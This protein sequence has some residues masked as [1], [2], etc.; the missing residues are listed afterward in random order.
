MATL[1]ITT[2]GIIFFFIFISI[3]KGAPYLPSHDDA[4]E[5]MLKLSGVI[6]GQKVVDIGS[7]DGRIVTA[8]AQKGAVVHGY[9]INPFLVMWSFYRIKRL[10]LG[11]RAFVHWRSFWGQSLKDFEVV[12]VFG[13]PHIMK[14]LEE[15]LKKE[16][17]PGSK[18]LS[19]VFKFPSWPEE[20]KDGAVRLYIKKD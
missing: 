6:E 8:F 20:A 9:E 14:G 2:G 19:Y 15:K 3:V 18:V 4:I 11:D 12:T 17:A 10:G 1:I 5:K 13:A 16:L 7:G